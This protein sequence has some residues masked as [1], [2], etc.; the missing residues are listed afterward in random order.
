MFGSQVLV[1]FCFGGWESCFVVLLWLL[2]F[3]SVASI[4]KSLPVLFKLVN[5][6]HYFLFSV[7]LCFHLNIEK[8][9]IY[10]GFF[11]GIF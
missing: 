2:C 9:V 8:A 10:L 11:W 1:L 3:V 6:K 4:Q 7:E 5:I